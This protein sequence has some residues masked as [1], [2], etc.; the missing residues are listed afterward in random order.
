VAEAITSPDFQVQEAKRRRA[1]KRLLDFFV[2]L[3]KRPFKP[4]LGAI[5]D[6]D[7]RAF[8]RTTPSGPAAASGRAGRGL[9]LQFLG[10]SSGQEPHPHRVSSERDRFL[11]VDLP[12]SFFPRSLFASSSCVSSEGL[13]S[14]S[15]GLRP[16]PS[17]VSLGQVC[18]LPAPHARSRRMLILLTNHLLEVTPS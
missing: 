18:A 7:L 10:A 1:G 16:C 6:K 15:S 12:G 5:I 2:A 13:R 14:G 8:F 4:E 11:N 3:I 17:N 9:C